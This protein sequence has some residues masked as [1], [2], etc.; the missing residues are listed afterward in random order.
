MSST[1]ANL[2]Q[3]SRNARLEFFDSLNVDRIATGHTQSDQTETVLVSL[4]SR[5][6]D[7]RV[8][9][10]A[11]GYR[12]PNSSSDRLHAVTGSGL[13]GFVS[14][15][16]RE[17]STNSDTSYARNYIR[18]QI[19]PVLP[20]GVET[21]L[22]RTADLARDEEDYWTSEIDRLAGRYLQARRLKPFS[23]TPI[24]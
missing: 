7:R 18:H 17:D 8:G 9:G 3:A 16:W 2:E 5:V 1:R 10:R 12:S 23:S 22:A 19:L 4:A 20:Q 21:V 13:F 15:S 24:T 11:S 14:Y 6:R